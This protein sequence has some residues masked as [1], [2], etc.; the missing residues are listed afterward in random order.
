M[1]FAATVGLLASAGVFCICGPDVGYPA[2]SIAAVAGLSA[3]VALLQMVRGSQRRLR[4]EFAAPPPAVAR[5]ALGA[6]RNPLPMPRPQYDRDGSRTLRTTHW[7]DIVVARASRRRRIGNY[8]NFFRSDAGIYRPT[9][10]GV[11]EAQSAPYDWQGLWDFRWAQLNTPLQSFASDAASDAASGCLW[12]CRLSWLPR[13]WVN[14][15]LLGALPGVTPT[16]N[17]GQRTVTW[18]SVLQGPGHLQV[19]AGR[20]A[21]SKKIRFDGQPAQWP[22]ISIRQPLGCTFEID[23]E[24][25]L[26]FLS[27]NGTE[28]M[29]TRPAFGWWGAASPDEDGAQT[30]RLRVVEAD[31]INVNGMALRTVRLVPVA[32]DWAAATFPIYLDPS[33]VIS[34]T[35]DLEDTALSSLAAT[36]NYGANFYVR[37]TQVTAPTTAWRGLIRVMTSALP[38]GVYTAASWTYY[39]TAAAGGDVLVKRVLPGND[40]VEGT[41]VAGIQSGS[42]CWDYVKHNTQAWAGSSGCNTSGVDYDSAL[43][44]TIPAATGS[45]TTAFAAAGVAAFQGWYNS[46]FANEGFVIGGGGAS[47]TVATLHTQ[48]YGVN[49]WTVEIFYD[50]AGSGGRIVTHSGNAFGDKAI[51]RPAFPGHPFGDFLRKLVQC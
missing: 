40:W 26:V 48:E 22:R 20:H 46:T 51:G 8:G 30:G 37:Y 42:T 11:E 12:G 10:L 18:P 43:A 49:P 27:A 31:P 9:A 28:Y 19:D 44:L 16:P 13:L 5:A 34:G 45:S 21:L 50:V 6:T 2:W 36:S 41:A 33:L 32:E 39:N 25:T 17:L 23:N 47:T 38:A 14:F 35:T 4:V 7:A 24:T 15:K 3:V 29:R 1:R